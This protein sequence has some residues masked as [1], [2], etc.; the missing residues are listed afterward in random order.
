M[1]NTPFDYSEDK[2]SVYFE[3]ARPPIVAEIL[4][5]I[6]FVRDI[7][8][9][10]YGVTLSLAIQQI[11]EVIVEISSHNEAIYGVVPKYLFESNRL[12]NLNVT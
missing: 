2:I 4:M 7:L 3:V 8:I 11:P 10:E 12:E 6:G 5:E 9:R 1:K